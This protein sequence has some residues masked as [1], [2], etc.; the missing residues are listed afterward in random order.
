MGHK[1]DEKRDTSV[2]HT[3]SIFDTRNFR[4]HQKRPLT[5][6]LLETEN[7][8]Y[9][10]CYP[11]LWFTKICEIKQ[12]KRAAP[13]TFRNTRELTPENQNKPST[14]FSVS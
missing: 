1:K 7:S 10:L 12:T 6:I 14:D 11:I 3:F 5:K 8:P 13:E 2:K 4:K 9:F